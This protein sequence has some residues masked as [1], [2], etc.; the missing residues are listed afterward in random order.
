MRSRRLVGLVLVLAMLAG[1][2]A[3]CR[4]LGDKSEWVSS[5]WSRGLLLGQ[6]V[7][8]APV[9][10][11]TDVS[12]ENIF[13]VWVTESA[14]DG[15]EFLHFAHLD[16]R[17]QVRATHNLPISAN[18][19]TQIELLMDPSG[20]LHLA[21]LDR[22]GGTPRLFY[23]R[24]DT[25]GQLASYPQPLTP[26]EVAVHSFALGLAPPGGVDLLWAAKEGQG[27]G[28]YHVRLGGAGEVVAENRALGRK[29]FAPALRTDR[30]GQLHLAWYEEPQYDEY[31]LYYASL[32]PRQRT[33]SAPLEITSFGAGGGVSAYRPS[34]GL[35][36]ED[37]Y[38]FW[39]T[40]RAGRGNSVPGAKTAYVT[41][42]L[43]APQAASAIHTVELPNL[44]APRYQKLSSR[45]PF[46]QWADPRVG[47]PSPYVYLP[48]SSQGH[49]D[50]LVVAFA[51]Q[52][53]SR[54]RSNTQIVVTLWSGR[55]LRGYQVA[56]KTRGLSNRPLLVLDGQRHA[57]LAWISPA[58]FG[59]FDVYF[60][61]TVPTL[62]DSLNGL[63]GQDI[64]A[65]VM[66]VLWELVQ[67]LAFLPIALVWLLLPLMSLAIYAFISAEDQ[68][69]RRGP[70]VML[71]LALALYTAFKYLFRAEWLMALPL[72]T[73]WPPAV[74]TTLILAAPLAV[75]GLAGLIM[76]RYTS[77]R[78]AP[79]IFAAFGVF[80]AA[81]ALLTVLIYVPGM[82]A[83]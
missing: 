82:L 59:A 38:L 80:V 42:P 83:E 24:L 7:L 58:G 29:G 76:W 17:A 70:R 72:P 26:A 66:G 12:G 20:W 3:G 52:V 30:Q 35:A 27:A 49:G 74:V 43:R 45:L 79:S 4:L 71:M 75:S 57:H 81:D 25:S 37:V 5:D 65:A 73:T 67:A 19:P 60:A 33:L 44:S 32:D 63:T 21:W 16:A 55:E 56:G 41:L 77:R 64:L 23:A 34:V 39:S 15:P 10:L 53:S 9:A 47:S 40:E 11:T 8:N 31:H 13:V 62:R 46:Q 18:R 78:E 50:E 2:L 22:L 48:S 68:L 6:A 28:L 1:S 61:S 69:G 54:T 51:V 14:G 36:G